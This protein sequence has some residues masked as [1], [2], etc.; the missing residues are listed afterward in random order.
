MKSGGGITEWLK[1]LGSYVSV[2]M[3]NRAFPESPA[4]MNG[5]P[6]DPGWLEA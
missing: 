1:E 5:E 4:L 2:E 6:S 3:P